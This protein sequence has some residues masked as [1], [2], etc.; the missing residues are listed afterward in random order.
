MT[1]KNLHLIVTLSLTLFASA[2]NGPKKTP[3]PAPSPSA[4]AAPMS[5]LPPAAQMMQATAQSCRAG[6]QLACER[7]RAMTMGPS[8]YAQE[9]ARQQE[10]ALDSLCRAGNKEACELEKSRKALPKK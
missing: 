9:Q 1:S 2:C 4:V 7:M 8:N 10:Q 6:D 5:Q 3:P